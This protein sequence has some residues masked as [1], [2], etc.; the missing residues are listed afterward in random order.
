MIFKNMKNLLSLSINLLYKFF[1]IF[2]LFILSFANKAQAINLENSDMKFS[3]QC[4]LAIKKQEKEKSIP[5]NLLYSIALFESGTYNSDAKKIAPWPWSVNISG[6]GYKFKTKIEAVK[7]VKDS[8]KNGHQSIDVGCMQVNLK[9]H[10][11]AFK[12]IEQAFDPYLNVKYAS[13]FLIEKFSQE[14]SWHKAVANYHSAN[15]TLGSKY[16]NSV[17]NIAETIKL[18]LDEKYAIPHVTGNIKK[19][20]V[21]FIKKISKRKSSSF[22][23]D[24]R[25]EKSR[26]NI[27]LYNKRLRVH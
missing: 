16:K 12:T 21:L 17:L 11:N 3:N 15:P 25:R 7:F 23:S 14:G 24:T 13:Q 4:I 20:R 9:Y 10:P 8:I 1:I 5:H 22:F 27:M 19:K 26:T 2:C 18:K 6:K